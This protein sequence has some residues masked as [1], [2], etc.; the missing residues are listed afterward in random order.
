MLLLAVL[1]FSFS[2][3]YAQTYEIADSLWNEAEK[4]HEAAEFLRA[5]ELYEMSALAELKCTEPRE[6]D[7]Y[8][9]WAN[10][11]YC[12]HQANRYDQAFEMRKKSLE[13]C[14][15]VFGKEH[16]KYGFEAA[17]VLCASMWRS[18]KDIEN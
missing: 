3:T 8:Y 14:I 1:S 17:W 5:A 16:E 15:N 4:A 18:K 13:Q 10:A 2:I 7:L 6:E 9:E 11:S 12:Y